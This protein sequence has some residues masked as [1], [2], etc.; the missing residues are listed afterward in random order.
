[1]TRTQLR[2]R[3]AHSRRRSSTGSTK[4]H[5]C[6]AQPAHTRACR[7]VP[8][9]TCSMAPLVLRRWT[10]S[11]ARR[12]TS[13]GRP[14]S[15]SRTWCACMRGSRVW[16]KTRC[17][18]PRKNCAWAGAHH[19][20]APRGSVCSRKHRPPCP[21]AEWSPVLPRAAAQCCR[22]QEARTCSHE[23]SGLPRQAHRTTPPRHRAVMPHLCT[24]CRAAA[25]HHSR[26]CARREWRRRASCAH[27]QGPGGAS[28]QAAQLAHGR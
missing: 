5:M 22:A 15:R 16:Q 8:E 28:D 19:P 6:A 21:L 24:R 4:A 1:M 25:S 10:A 26:P 23:S 27:A 9:T 17:T 2:A 14:C 12:G 11:L 13:F 7:R 20:P 18:R 3:S